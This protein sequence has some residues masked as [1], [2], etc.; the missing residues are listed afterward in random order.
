MRR[1]SSEPDPCAALDVPSLPD[2]LRHFPTG[3]GHLAVMW[4]LPGPHHVKTY[5]VRRFKDSCGTGFELLLARISRGADPNLADQEAGRQ[6][7]TFLSSGPDARPC[8]GPV[9]ARPPAGPA[10]HERPCQGCG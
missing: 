1:T 5:L 7:E 2:T 4:L 10:G 6:S 8:R 3:E 9:R